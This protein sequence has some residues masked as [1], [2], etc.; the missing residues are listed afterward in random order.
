MIKAEQVPR[1]RAGDLLIF[2]HGRTNVLA[3][4]LEDRGCLGVRGQRIYQAEPLNRPGW[5]DPVEVPE[6]EIKEVIIM[7]D[8]FVSGITNG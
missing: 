2:P 6:D 3:K 8:P 1:L 4:V 5:T 7:G